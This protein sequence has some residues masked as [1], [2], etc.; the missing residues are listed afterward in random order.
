MMIDFRWGFFFL[1][2]SSKIYEIISD[3]VVQALSI[4]L[5]FKSKSGEAIG[6]AFLYVYSVSKSSRLSRGCNKV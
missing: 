5:L 6:I 2:L 1:L 4:G 3:L